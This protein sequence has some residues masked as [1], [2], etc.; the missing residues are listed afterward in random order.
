MLN[1]NLEFYLNIGVTSILKSSFTQTLY[2]FL[3]SNI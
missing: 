2:L 1:E 3:I